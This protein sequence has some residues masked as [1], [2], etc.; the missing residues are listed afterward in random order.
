MSYLKHHFMRLQKNND[1]LD[2]IQ[3]TDARYVLIL[4][5]TVNVGYFDPSEWKGIL[6]ITEETPG[7]TCLISDGE[8]RL[9]L[10]DY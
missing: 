3:K 9:Y 4:D 7:F 10:I 2:A 5:E 1:V 8:M 6:N